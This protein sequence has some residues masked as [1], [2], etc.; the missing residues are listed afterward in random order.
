MHPENYLTCYGG[1]CVCDIGVS[2]K[3]QGWHLLSV[4]KRKL[5]WEDAFYNVHSERC[6]FLCKMPVRV[7]EYAMDIPL[8]NPSHFPGGYT[9]PREA[10]AILSDR[11]F[12]LQG[13]HIVTVPVDGVDPDT[14]CGPKC[15]VETLDVPDVILPDP[16][17]VV[18]EPYATLCL[19]QVVGT[20]LYRYERGRL[21][22]M[23]LDTREWTM[24]I[25]TPD[26]PTPECDVK[27]CSL[28][29]L[30][31]DLFLVTGFFVK[32]EKAYDT[33]RQKWISDLS[34]DPTTCD[35][36]YTN[37]VIGDP[38]AM[39]RYDLERNR[40]RVFQVDTAFRTVY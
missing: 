12:L 34:R 39:V 31:D 15:K 27:S 25:G 9:P 3:G 29:S 16:G 33:V 36:V 5:A 4:K 22:C 26:C 14:R 24:V 13:N 19:Y 20:E 8:M 11:E 18:R 2:S 17:T 6:N 23:A 7:R 30:D 40:L 37:R 10:L 38:R 32:A 28:F 35:G 1:G 21:L